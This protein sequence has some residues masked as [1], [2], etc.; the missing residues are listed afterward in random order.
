MAKKKAKVSWKGR[1]AVAPGQAQVKG[2]VTHVITNREGHTEVQVNGT[3]G[4]RK[5][6]GFP[7][8]PAHFLA[9][10]LRAQSSKLP[11]QVFYTE[12]GGVLNVQLVVVFSK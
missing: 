2:Q 12:E 8:N 7:P 1:P 5:I 11:V 6:I 4:A 3:K 9:E 10:L